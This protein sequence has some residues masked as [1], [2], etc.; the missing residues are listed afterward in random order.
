MVPTSWRYCVYAYVRAQSLPSCLTLCDPVPCSSP[1]KNTGVGCH[2]LRQG[3]SRPRDW[4]RNSCIAGRF[5]T[6][7]PPGKPVF[8]CVYISIKD[9]VWHEFCIQMSCDLLFYIHCTQLSLCHCMFSLK[10]TC[11]ESSN[12]SSIFVEV[13]RS[14]CKQM[15]GLLVELM[16]TSET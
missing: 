7:E 11:Q 15:E 3:S 10:F 2:A 8:M 5:C 13:F 9:V 4:T 6:A 16:V 14:G 12:Q 1:G